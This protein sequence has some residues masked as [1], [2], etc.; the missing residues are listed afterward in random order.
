MLQNM[1]IGINQRYDVVLFVDAVL[2]VTTEMI[3]VGAVIFNTD[4]RAQATLSKPLKGSLSVFQA[5][6]LPLLVGLR[7]AESIGFPLKNISSYSLMLVQALNST[8]VYHNELGML[9]DD[10]KMLME[11]F[12]GAI[13]SH[14]NHKFN[15]AA[16]NLSKQALQLDGE[17]I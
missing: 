15:L 9:L 11:N 12:S 8:K 5:E 2:C 7:W 1:S 17:L 16:H 3:G 14:V 6:A 13:I 10:I 4:K